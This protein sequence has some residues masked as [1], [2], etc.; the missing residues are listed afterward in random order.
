MNS[1]FKATDISKSY[2]TPTGKLEILKKLNLSLN[3]DEVVAILGVSGVG[4]S[5]LLHVLGTLD[6]PDEGDIFLNEKNLCLLDKEDLNKFRC[7]NLGFVFQFHYLL[8]EFTSLENVS[9]PGFIRKESKSVVEERAR[10]LLSKLGLKDRLL[11]RPSQLSF[12][13]Q[14]RVAIARA[15]MNDPEIILADEPT[16]N[17]DSQT[18]KEVFNL[19][20]EMVKERGKILIFVTHN[21]ELAKK[22]DRIF[23]LKEGNLLEINH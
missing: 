17:L 2:Y 13:E 10:M 14:Q 22:A 23:R 19:L 5:T 21:E 8:P 7:E 1:I 12:G 3:Q 20:Y 18:T 9:L 11:H 6:K 4:K 15:L 16:G